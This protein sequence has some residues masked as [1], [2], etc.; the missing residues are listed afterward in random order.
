[1]TFPLILMMVHHP[2]DRAYSLASQVKSTW[3][4]GPK[5]FSHALEAQA[6]LLMVTSWLERTFLMAASVHL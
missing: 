2:E 3:P 5:C 6:Y 4:D 1:M